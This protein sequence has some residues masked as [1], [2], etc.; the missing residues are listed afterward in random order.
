MPQVPTVKRLVLDTAPFLKGTRLTG[1]AESYYT[2][3]E[4]LGEI[5]DPVSRD[6][7]QRSGLSLQVRV[8]TAE[9]IQ[10]VI[11]FS[12][13]TGDFPVLSKVDIKV[14][15]LVHTLEMEA[16]GGAQI[17]TEPKPPMTNAEKKAM[18]SKRRSRPSSSETA[19]SKDDLSVSM[20]ELNLKEEIPVETCLNS[21]EEDDGD[22][23][24][25]E[26]IATQ[27]FSLESSDKAPSSAEAK[28]AKTDTGCMTGDFAMQVH[29]SRF[30]RHKRLTCSRTSSFK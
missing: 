28:E 15:A 25:P 9:S 13:K 10:A 3:P 2:I 5:Q 1:L 22:W 23:I 26:N 21:D 14:L 27:S 7:L 30:E 11:D 29:W 20:A 6:L 12:K 17:R 19:P 24:T 8:P 18:E 16:N 4:V